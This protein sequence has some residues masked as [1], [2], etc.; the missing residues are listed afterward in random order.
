MH[1]R[2]LQ[3]ADP[4]W[5]APPKAAAWR[6]CVLDQKD[7]T[8]ERLKI[9]VKMRFASMAPADAQAVLGAERQ[10]ERAAADSNATYAARLVNAWTL[11][12]RAGT[13]LGLLWALTDAGY[14]EAII[15][16]A[17]GLAFTLVNNEFV[18]TPLPAGSWACDARSEE[19]TSELQSQR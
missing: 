1:F 4:S 8:L 13:A 11:W 6:R 16:I 10:L 2:D 15:A 18:T 9:A 3:A 7:A 5:L 12:Q 19:H 14:P 17:R